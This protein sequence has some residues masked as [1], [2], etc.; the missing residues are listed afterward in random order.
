MLRNILKILTNWHPS[1]NEHLIEASNLC[2]RCATTCSNSSGVF[3]SIF[4]ARWQDRWVYH[5]HPKTLLW[6]MLSEP[7][8]VNHWCICI[9]IYVHIPIDNM[10]VFNSIQVVKKK[11]MTVYNHTSERLKNQQRERDVSTSLR[12][13]R[14]PLCQCTDGTYSH[15]TQQHGTVRASNKMDKEK[16][17]THIQR[18]RNSR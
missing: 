11:N 15:S 4:G 2:Y 12:T 1:W 13:R 7:C 16:S 5:S 10:C 8:R 18:A 6:Q 17:K 3:S 14:S 9:H